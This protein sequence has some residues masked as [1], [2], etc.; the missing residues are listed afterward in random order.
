[1]YWFE[2]HGIVYMYVYTVKALLRGVP[3]YMQMCVCV[4][5]YSIFIT[6]SKMYISYFINYSICIC[7]LVQLNI[8]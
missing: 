6:L 3:L 7:L 2:L 4:N 8:Y 1:M 5:V